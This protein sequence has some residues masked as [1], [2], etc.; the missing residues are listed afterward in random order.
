MELSNVQNC[1]R[2][3][4]VKYLNTLDLLWDLYQPNLLTDLYYF[5]YNPNQIFDNHTPY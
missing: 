4:A 3:V 2:K 5:L 1:D